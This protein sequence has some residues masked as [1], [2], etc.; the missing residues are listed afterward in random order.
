MKIPWLGNQCIFCLQEGPLSEEH[1]IPK[2]LGGILTS[3]FICS[4][5]NSQFGHAVEATAKSDPVVFF[6][7]K[8][9]SQAIP[10]L[11]KRLVE[12]RSHIGYGDLGSLSGYIRNNEFSIKSQTLNDGSIIQPQ[13]DARKSIV[14]ILQKS[15]YGEE[16]I[17]KALAKHDE[18]TE[19]KRVK[20]VPGLEIVKRSIQEIEP[21]MSKWRLMDKL[22]PAKIAFEFL[23]AHVGTSICDDVPQLREVR[24]V[25][26]TSTLRK[27]VVQVERLYSKEYEPFHGI[28]F[29]G[30]DPHA[31]V[32]IR[33]FGWLAVRVNFLHLSIGGPRFVYTHKLNTNKEFIG[34]INKARDA[35]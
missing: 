32:Q 25:L 11:S 26:R 18:V 17:R 6:A 29:E 3:E 15:G 8:N 5:C 20:L 30:N 24:Q 12:G 31:K 22:V 16:P 27:D 21:D 14:K 10:R 9:L 2:S 1:L 33:L 35:A 23:A 4:S 34:T 7:A 28:C 19:G 13:D